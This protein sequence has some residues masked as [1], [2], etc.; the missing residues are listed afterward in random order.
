MTK[1]RFCYFFFIFY[2]IRIASLTADQSLN[3][4]VILRQ[5]VKFKVKVYFDLYL[6]FTIVGFSIYKYNVESENRTRHCNLLKLF[7]YECRIAYHTT[8]VLKRFLE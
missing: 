7:Y 8:T 4:E 1:M 6:L 5:L 3:D 2:F